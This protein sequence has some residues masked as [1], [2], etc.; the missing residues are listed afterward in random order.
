MV[1]Q[2]GGMSQGAA[3]MG[4]GIAARTARLDVTAGAVDRANAP[5]V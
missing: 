2:D 4:R 5:V 1:R 3:A